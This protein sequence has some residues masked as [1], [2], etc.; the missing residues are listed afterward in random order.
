MSRFPFKGRLTN[1]FFSCFLVG[2]KALNKFL[3]DRFTYFA[4][5]SYPNGIQLTIDSEFDIGVLQGNRSF[6]NT[7]STISVPLTLKLKTHDPRAYVSDRVKY[8]KIGVYEDPIHLPPSAP[9][10]A[11][12]TPIDFLAERH[13]IDLI[14]IEIARARD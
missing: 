13:C 8:F 10:R 7:I 2:E 1:G 12:L 5:Y 14:T 6:E 11:K 4:D 9:K 3:P